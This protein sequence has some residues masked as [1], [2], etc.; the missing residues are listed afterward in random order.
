MSTARRGAHGARAVAQ[1]ARRARPDPRDR[2]TVAV[3]RVLRR[4]AVM[5]AL[6]RFAALATLGLSLAAPSVGSAQPSSAQRELGQRHFTEGVEAARDGRWEDAERAFERAWQLTEDVVVLI[7]LAAAQAERGRL[8]DATRSF[9]A[10]LRRSDADHPHRERAAQSIAL[11]R[12]RIAHLRLS[13]DG[14]A[15]TDVLQLDGVALA[16][17]VVGDALP[18]DPGEHSL[19]VERAERVVAR[20]TLLVGAGDE[21]RLSLS[22]PA[23]A[24][25]PPAMTGA[26]ADGP[27]RSLLARAWPWL[28]GAVLVV[29]AATIVGLTVRA[30]APRQGNLGHVDY[31]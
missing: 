1:R 11:L 8:V 14:L 7:N 26:D 21:T 15:P 22:L 30:P 23:L 13:I 12:P 2:R 6:V 29:V 5:D 10:F 24:A 27:A 16:H 20:R 9:R 28:T 31:P 18:L 3:A 17:A 4:R 19:R 25:A